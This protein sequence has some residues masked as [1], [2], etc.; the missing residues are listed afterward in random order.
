[1]AQ[2]NKAEE[3]EASIRSTIQDAIWNGYLTKTEI[4]ALVY[5]ALAKEDIR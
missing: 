1:M 5:A 3:F 4:R 2:P